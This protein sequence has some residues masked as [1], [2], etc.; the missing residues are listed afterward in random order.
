MLALAE[1]GLLVPLDRLRARAFRV[2]V[3]APLGGVL[4]RKDA[5]ILLRA[6]LA[7]ALALATTLWAP[8]WLFALAPLVL[9]VPHLA[10]DVRYL[11][12]R[13]AVSRAARAALVAG[14]LPF[15][16]VRLLPLVGLRIRGEARLEIA[17]AIGALGLAAVL[18]AHA[19]GRRRRALLCLPL[20]ALAWV[21]LA[22]ADAARLVFAHAHNLVAL[23][24]W[25]VV[26]RRG[27]TRRPVVV[28]PIALAVAGAA[29]LVIHGAR[30]SPEAIARSGAFG[31]SLVRL[32]AWLAPGLPASLAAGL[33]L[34]YVFLQSVHYSIW[35]GVIPAEVVRGQAGRSWRMTWKALLRELRPAGL[36]LVALASLGLLGGALV[37]VH[38]ARDAYLSLSAFHGYLELAALVL[39]S[40]GMGTRLRGEAPRTTSC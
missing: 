35:L 5:R 34:S 8:L 22:H 33:A 30:L 3:R 1:A 14:C 19:T 29:A 7:I 36:V 32:G 4:V 17:M 31:L 39:A 24:L 16:L 11:I 2:L 10:A 15:V 27:A 12:V 26:F 18:G 21:A 38:R 40:V 37:D 25:A 20:G 23:I 13:P 28:L 6:T 9:G